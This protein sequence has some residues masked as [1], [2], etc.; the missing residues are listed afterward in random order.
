M[1]DPAGAPARMFAAELTDQRLHLGTRLV[2][3]GGRSMGAV[4]EGGEPTF[5][6]TGDPGV[7]TLA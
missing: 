2:R 3:A 6:V 4:R 1:L 7:N 5:L